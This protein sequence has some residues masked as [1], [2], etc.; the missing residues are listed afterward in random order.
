[1]KENDDKIWDQELKHYFESAADSVKLDKDA[2]ERILAGAHRQIQ[3]R[4]KNMGI[5]KKKKAVIIAA[6]AAVA[7]LGT[8]TAV[9]AGTIEGLFTSVNTQNVDYSSEE[10]IKGAK[11]VLGAVPK[12]PDEFSNGLKL[13]A[14]YLRPV[15]GMDASGTVVGSYPSLFV[16]Y[17]MEISLFIEKIPDSMKQD[18]KSP[19]ETAEYN[20]IALE[21]TADN[22]LFLPPDAQPSAEDQELEQAGELYISYGTDKEEK[23][24][25]EVVSWEEDGLSYMISDFSGEYGFEDLLQMAKEVIDVETE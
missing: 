14:G 21:L 5:I 22:Y 6:A 1:M 3:E 12:A 23:K 2:E 17:G 19:D 25:F 16:S 18:A 10:E 8:I 7:M 15:N 13:E 4:K 20:G 9:G 11:S 24:T